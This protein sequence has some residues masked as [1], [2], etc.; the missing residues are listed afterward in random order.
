MCMAISTDI[1][2]NTT[3]SLTAKA[4]YHKLGSANNKNISNILINI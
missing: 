3:K 2:P 4:K 1:I